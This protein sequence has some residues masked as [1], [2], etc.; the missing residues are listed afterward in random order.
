MVF[1]LVFGLPIYVYS[2]DNNSQDINSNNPFNTDGLLNSQQVDPTGYTYDPNN[3]SSN[4]NLSNTSS[5]QN[6]QG[7]DTLYG[8]YNT[9]TRV[10]NSNTSSNRNY[11][12][13]RDGI[14]PLFPT[15]NSPDNVNTEGLV[16]DGLSCILAISATRLASAAL[17]FGQEIAERTAN[18]V[19]QDKLA[20]KIAAASGDGGF[21]GLG[22]I[23][24]GA[25]GS[26]VP[27]AGTIIGSAVGNAVGGVV[28]SAV[29]TVSNAATAATDIS[30]VKTTGSTQ[31]E[32]KEAGFDIFGIP[33]GPSLD[34]IEF[35]AKNLFIAY[36]QAS[37]I[38]WV[39]NASDKGAAFVEDLEKTINDVANIAYEEAIG[40]ITLCAHVR[41]NVELS[42]LSRL[43]RSKDT[44]ER[45]G[46]T[47][48]LDQEFNLMLQGEAFDYGRFYRL[49][50]DPGGNSMNAFIEFDNQFEGLRK[51]YEDNL[52]VELGW[53]NGFWPWKVDGRTLTPGQVVE[54][55][56]YN[57]LSLNTDNLV[58]ADEMDE[59]IF[60]I[61]NQLI[62]VQLQNSI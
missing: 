22:G 43:L 11:I 47:V 23:V 15:K 38:E 2:Q 32:I 13:L 34:G 41:A 21:G 50:N 27:G 4:F 25:V 55:K 58:I 6:T 10:G 12:E 33:A 29:S 5:I 3:P 40:E 46:C 52:L 8:N 14:N 59:L 54:Q 53:S 17:S 18:G 19:W 42:A 35:C 28:N 51:K 30:T 60:I 61:F 36:L 56:L 24:G 62:K 16:T 31:L 39:N 26:V 45:S 1:S 57:A 20:E 48:E 44:P 37:I 9:N 7:T 49:T